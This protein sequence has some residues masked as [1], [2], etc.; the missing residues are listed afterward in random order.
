MSES[1]VTVLICD[2]QAIVRDGLE[3]ILSAEP[4]LAIV[5]VAS[6]GETAIELCA[7]L[8]P[9]V[10]LMDLNMPGIGGTEA[11]RRLTATERPPR[12]LV[13]TT[14]AD[15]PTV[16][17]ALAA[18]ADGYLLKDAP[19]T[20]ITA[21]IKHTAQG[22]APL[23]AAISRV[24]VDAALTRQ[25]P[26]ASTANTKRTN[27]GLTDREADI[28]RLITQ[29][30]SNPAIGQELHLSTGTVRNHVSRILAKLSATDRAH[31][32]AIAVTHNII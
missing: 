23:D 13:L 10:V 27:F 32:A 2:D 21:A 29:G 9:D 18:G 17:G 20:E 25:R 5:G 19:R 16:M 30:H 7:E 3:A 22:R 1:P 15:E 31:A 28:L 6:D 26:D 8:I 11:T 14:Y 24:V 4:Q 12:I